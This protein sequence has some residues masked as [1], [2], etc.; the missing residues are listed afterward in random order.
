M[1]QETTSI[2]RYETPQD[3]LS[4]L[5]SGTIRLG[6]DSVLVTASHRMA[7]ALTDARCAAPVPAGSVIAVGDL[8][9]RLLGEWYDEKAQLAASLDLVGNFENGTATLAPEDLAVLR[10]N[11][12]NL[13][14]SIEALAELG[15]TP[16]DDR[17]DDEDISPAERLLW[18]VYEEAAQSNDFIFHYL[19]ET[20]KWSHAKRFLRRLNEL[21]FAPRRKGAAHVP[22]HHAFERNHGTF[23]LHG[24]YYITPTQSCFIDALENAGIRVVYLNR[25]DAAAPEA[26]RVFDENPRFSRTAR[27]ANEP[28]FS[29]GRRFCDATDVQTL[30]GAGNPPTAFAGLFGGRD[31]TRAQRGRLPS[32]RRF[33]DAFSFVDHI[34]S[35]ART[36]NEGGKPAIVLSPG[37][38]DLI[39]FFDTFFPQGDTIR[40]FMAYPFGQYLCHIYA[41]WDFREHAPICAPEDMAACL[42]TG[43]A[44]DDAAGTAGLLD[45]YRRASAFFEDASVLWNADGWK[46][47]LDLLGAS[48]AELAWQAPAQ[49]PQDR[50]AALDTEQGYWRAIAAMNLTKREYELLRS[51][52]GNVFHD[53]QQLFACA[54]TVSL[55]EHFH[56]LASF[57]S[58]KSAHRRLSTEERNALGV[59]RSRLLGGD[60]PGRASNC[61]V[62]NLAEVMALYLRGRLRPDTDEEADAALHAVR[63]EGGDGAHFRL[64]GLDAVEAESLLDPAAAFFVCFADEEHFPGHAKHYTWPLSLPMLLRIASET[65]SVVKQ[66]RIAEYLHMM[67]NTVLSNRY[68][69]YLLLQQPRV[70]FSRLSHYQKKDVE[71]SP[72]LGLLETRYPAALF[73]QPAARLGEDPQRPPALPEPSLAL[74]DDDFLP[75]AAGAHAF[76]PS[77]TP[78]RGCPAFVAN[79]RACPYRSF[80]DFGLADHPSYDATYQLSFVLPNIINILTGRTAVPHH[81]QKARKTAER[82]FPLWNGTK[83]LEILSYTSKLGVRYYQ[84]FVTDDGRQPQAPIDSLYLLHPYRPNFRVLL[85]GEARGPQA[86]GPQGNAKQNT[87]QADICRYCPHR[88]VCFAKDRL[89]QERDVLGN[90]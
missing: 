19:D 14:L 46:R 45:I 35:L 21:D 1:N 83:M 90:E 49:P 37:S 31:D 8:L 87:Q 25:Y 60:L 55:D 77:D 50:W 36:G 70:E 16:E 62:E 74:T 28:A 24:F 79:R 66:R 52:I 15:I 32:F 9:H 40:H 39:E 13:F 5:R 69:F 71:R 53:A 38:R 51:A 54:G 3:I 64:Q 89:I 30:A 10:K 75:D 48:L 85:K 18:D 76:P 78:V 27:F 12:S 34:Q 82:C 72:Y 57:L 86:A 7:E 63:V 73:E 65:G 23:Y 59:I 47:R 88:S 6:T 44:A 56:R 11:R 58:E 2:L 80:Y 33:D 81:Y 84:P 43:W 26:F 20:E 42:A 67:E 68:L 41:A 4:A 29:K 61:H 22:V 17:P